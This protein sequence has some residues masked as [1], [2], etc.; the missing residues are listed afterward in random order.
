MAGS[1]GNILSLSRSWT[2]RYCVVGKDD[3]CELLHIVVGCLQCLSWNHKT[4][5]F[6]FLY[7]SL[8]PTGFCL[9]GFL[10][11]KQFMKEESNFSSS[12][13]IL[14]VL[15]G[16]LQVMAVSPWFQVNVIRDHVGFQRVGQAHCIFILLQES[17]R[18]I[19]IP[20]VSIFKSDHLLHAANIQ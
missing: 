5:T 8:N 1:Y 18:K 6:F 3:T 10:P 20:F 15:G 2:I 4:Y 9:A 11:S 7:P 13:K 19:R 12:L 14:C 17:E 16:V